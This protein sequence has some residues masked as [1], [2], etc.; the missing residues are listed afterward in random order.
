M[1]ND[2][3]GNIRPPKDPVKTKDALVVTSLR[4][5]ADTQDSGPH[6]D[7]EIAMSLRLASALITKS[8]TILL[9]SVMIK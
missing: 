9:P 2:L 5:K 4:A 3:S 7:P 6:G 8:G 1:R